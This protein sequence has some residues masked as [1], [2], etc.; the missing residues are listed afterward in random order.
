LTPLEVSRYAF[1]QLQRLFEQASGIHLSADK[2][3]LVQARLSAH[4]VAL[5]YG[6]FD[7]YCRWLKHTSNSEELQIVIDLLTTNETYFFREPRHFAELAKQLS[8][9]FAGQPLRCWSAACSTGEEPYSIAM[10]L[11]DRCPE[12]S[13][14]LQASDLSLGVLTRARRGIFPMQRLELMP[15]GYLQRFCLRGVGEYEGMLRVDEAVRSRVH[16]FRHNLLDSVYGLGTFDVIFIR[17][18]LI[19]FDLEHKQQILSRVID[20]LRPAGLLFVGHAEPLQGLSL[21]LQRVGRTEAV[22]E[23][24][25]E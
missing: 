20:C 21:P 7:D 6:S 16:F 25:H 9:R 15:P 13:W 11:L 5:G 17:N 22:F 14:E 12:R 19:Y 2:I 3:G 8:S 18:V 23:L 10:T 4:V 1:E 24:A